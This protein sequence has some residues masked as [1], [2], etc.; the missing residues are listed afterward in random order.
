MSTTI[1][2]TAIGKPP[3]ARKHVRTLTGAFPASACASWCSSQFITLGYIPEKDEEGRE[4]WPIGDEKTWQAG[5]R[6][7]DAGECMTATLHALA[8]T[9]PRHSGDHQIHREPRA[10]VA[11]AASV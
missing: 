3:R 6:G 4:K 2:T 9:E 5:I 10:D 8:L 11:G 7:V 1:D